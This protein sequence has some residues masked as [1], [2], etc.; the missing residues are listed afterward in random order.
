LYV[1]DGKKYLIKPYRFLSEKDMP[2]KLLMNDFTVKCR[3]IL[4][5]MAEASGFVLKKDGA[6]SNDEILGSFKIAIQ[7]LRNKYSFLFTP[8]SEKK[9]HK[10]TL[11]TWSTRTNYGHVMRHGNDSDRALLPTPSKYN[12]PH[13]NKRKIVKVHFRDGKFCKT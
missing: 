7:H 12:K 3:P 8:A 9:F 1:N 6:M 13:Q 4:Q 10:W 2:T 11:G 5:R